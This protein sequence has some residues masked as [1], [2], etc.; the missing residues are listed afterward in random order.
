MTAGSIRLFVYGTLTCRDMRAALLGRDLDVDDAC[1]PGYVRLTLRM[2]ELA[3]VPAIVER[4]TESVAG[5]LVHDVDAGAL[6]VLDDFELAHADF[7]ARRAV[8]VETASGPLPAETYVAGSAARPY[9]GEA[10]DREVFLREYG[11]LYL[12][13]VIPEFL[14]RRA[15]RGR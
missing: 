6:E 4:D 9:L 5:Q 13:H 10:W 7:Y 1:L 15:R 11:A 3:P 2:P 12:D 14:V 8:V